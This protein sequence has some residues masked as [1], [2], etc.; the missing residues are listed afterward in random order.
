[1]YQN[2]TTLEAIFNFA[3]K[4]YSANPTKQHIFTKEVCYA[5]LFPLK[6]DN[7]T[8]DETV[9]ENSFIFCMMTILDETKDKEKYLHLVFIE[10]LDFLCR[11]AISSI[12]LKDTIEDKAYMLIKILWKYHVDKNFI[13]SYTYPLTYF[14][15]EAA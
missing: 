9:I 4:K 5:M 13:S 11:V 14:R 1:M 12:T 6:D 15:I 2:L 7:Y 8:Y 10:F 3:K